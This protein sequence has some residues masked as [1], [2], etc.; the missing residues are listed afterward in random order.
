MRFPDD[1][2]VT[3]AKRET[4]RARLAALGVDLAQV[5]EQAVRA[6]GPGGQKVNKTSSGVLLRYP[7]GAE[8]LVV[9]WTRERHRSLNRFLALREL[10]DEVELRVSPETSERLRDRER[11]RRRKDRARRRQR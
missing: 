3:P 9:K 8:L 10:A 7:L 6:S 5:D 1:S 4:L 2:P 11:V